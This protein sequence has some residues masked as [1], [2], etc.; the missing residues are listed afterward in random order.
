MAYIGI[1]H[2]SKVKMK[3]SFIKLFVSNLFF[4]LYTIFN[5]HQNVATL[6]SKIPL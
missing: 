2:P 5:T 6:S 1:K 4:N 3:A